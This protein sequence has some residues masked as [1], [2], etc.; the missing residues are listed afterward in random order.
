MSF[1]NGICLKLFIKR[2]F[3]LSLMFEIL[4]ILTICPIG[5]I[6]LSPQTE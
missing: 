5:D 6:L 1:L 3:L 2:I 4:D